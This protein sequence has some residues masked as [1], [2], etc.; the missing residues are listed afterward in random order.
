MASCNAKHW[1]GSKYLLLTV[2]IG[3]CV[4]LAGAAAGVA[5]GADR[6][7]ILFIIADDASPHFGAYGC[8]WVKTPNIRSRLHQV[9]RSAAGGCFLLLLVRQHQSA[10]PLSA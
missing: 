7:N 8:D 1:V 10:S 9:P 4:V 5:H 2:L 6:P 3:W